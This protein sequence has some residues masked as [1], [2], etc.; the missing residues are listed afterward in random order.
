[1]KLMTVVLAALAAAG[2]DDSPLRLRKL[3]DSEMA[4]EWA[5]QKVVPAPAC[6]DAAFVRRVTLDLAGTVPSY[7][8]TAAFLKDVDPEKRAKRIDRL[9]EDPRFAR[10]QAVEWDLV[11]FGRNNAGDRPGFLKWMT[12]RFARNDAYDTWVRELLL[13]EGNSVEHGAP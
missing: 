12:E 7:E 10:T 1:M 9:L 5:R 13:A 11:L 6:D 8:D 3:I 4:A 2:N